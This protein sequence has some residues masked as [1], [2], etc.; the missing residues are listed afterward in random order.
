MELSKHSSNYSVGYMLSA[1]V[2]L[3]GE[4]TQISIGCT[5]QVHWFIVILEKDKTKPN[6]KNEMCDARELNI[7]GNETFA[8]VVWKRGMHRSIQT[9]SNS[10]DGA[11]IADDT[12]NK[13]RIN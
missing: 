5:K 11:I 12:L 6:Q 8:C 13:E 1:N 9:I 7:I 3:V 4:P 10:I 2:V